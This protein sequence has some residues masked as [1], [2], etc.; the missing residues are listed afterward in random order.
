MRLYGSEFMVSVWG[1]GLEIGIRV[2]VRVHGVGGSAALLCPMSL[3]VEGS[4]HGVQCL[5]FGIWVWGVGGRV[6]GVGCGV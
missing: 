5:R 4:G 3:R 2:R 1:L 6:R